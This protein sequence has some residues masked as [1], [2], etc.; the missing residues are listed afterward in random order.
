MCR[1]TAVPLRK[2]LLNTFLQFK[3]KSRTSPHFLKLDYFP[4]L[5][6]TYVDD[7]GISL[8]HV[9]YKSIHPF[10]QQL[11]LLWVMWGLKNYSPEIQFN[12]LVE[13]SLVFAVWNQL[14]V[15]ET[16]TQRGVRRTSIKGRKQDLNCYRA[17]QPSDEC[18]HSHVSD[19][20][21]SATNRCAHSLE[22]H[23]MHGA[24]R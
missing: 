4:N 13:H 16:K 14:K 3:L 18:P 9:N 24:R 6:P 21:L 2:G 11:I 17:F 8:T 7:G 20:L 10:S 1:L 19:I 15:L 23:V 5:Q 22:G 12:H